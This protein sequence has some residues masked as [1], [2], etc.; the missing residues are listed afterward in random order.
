MIK[1]SENPRAL[2]VG[3]CPVVESGYTSGF[4]TS[5]PM[6][7]LPQPRRSMVSAIDACMIWPNCRGD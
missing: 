5:Q 4:D 7:V 1:R 3:C 6:I 2:P